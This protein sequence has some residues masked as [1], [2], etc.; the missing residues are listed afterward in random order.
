MSTSASK[1][2][3]A[4]RL[5]LG[6][7]FFVFGL[8]GFFGFIPMP[9][10]PEQAGAFMGALIQSGYL[11]TFVKVV[12]VLV[13]AMFLTGIQVPFALLLITPIAINIFLFHL[14]LVGPG[15]IGMSVLILGLIAYLA[16][17]H[18]QRYRSIFS[19]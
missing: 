1:L 3:L 11:F 10:L 2:H 6:L 12:E 7:I 17:F 4:A 5:I 19:S 9:P 13:G 14:V 18:R 15:T 16:W 8:N